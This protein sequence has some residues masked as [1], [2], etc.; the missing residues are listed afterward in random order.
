MVANPST[1]PGFR[2][3][4]RSLQSVGLSDAAF[5]ALCQANRDLRFERTAEGD[6]VVMSPTGSETG[7]RSLSIAAQLYAWAQRD[8][9]GIAFD[10]STGFA[11]PNGAVRSPDA[12]WVLR[13][14][15][16]TPS[17]PERSGFAP[18]CPNFV[19]EL[20]SPTDARGPLEAKLAEYMA[21]G[22][23]LGWLIDPETRQV[24]VFRPGREIEILGAPGRITGDPELRGLVV[25]LGEV[26][27][28]PG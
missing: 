14:R 24:S 19:V 8:G 11:L 23:R 28:T 5:L 2:L 18:V 9:D 3:A 10:S 21:N 12:A 27:E 16:T 1:A 4:I 7:R 15:Y 22:A 13:E 6:V 20:R 17:G 25:E 26:W